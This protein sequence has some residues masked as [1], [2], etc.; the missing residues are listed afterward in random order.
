M[1]ETSPSAQQQPGSGYPASSS[2]YA[3][4]PIQQQQQQQGGGGAAANDMNSAAARL[5][6]LQLASSGSSSAMALGSNSSGGHQGYASGYS[7]AAAAPAPAASAAAAAVSVAY[8]QAYSQAG[9][10][11]MT[12]IDHLTVAPAAA[13][14]PPPQM[15]SQSVSPVAAFS[16]QDNS[17]GA[18][19]SQQQPPP[20]SASGGSFA[21]GYGPQQPNAYGFNAVSPTQQ[22]QQQQQQQHLAPPQMQQ[23][24]Q[25]PTMRQSMDGAGQQQPQFQQQQPQFQQQQQ[26]QQP[27]LVLPPMVGPML[28]FVNVE[29][30][31]ALWHGSVLVLTNEALLPQGSR[32]APPAPPP[33]S[34]SAMHA[35]PTPVASAA[36]AP[37]AH[38]PIIEVWDDGVH[39]PGAG[40]PKTFQAKA[41]YTE[42][43]YK[44]TF[45]RA[46]VT[47]P[48]PQENEVEVLYQ[49]YW[50]ADESAVQSYTARQTHSFRLAAQASQWRMCVTSNN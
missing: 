22:Q 46:D 48:L 2:A 45:W 4:I 18:S 41:I 12:G 25:A 3:A 43:T 27:Q 19:R 28:Q 39:G 24:Q 36:Q 15:H 38:I 29:L 5:A 50:G 44:Y 35:G 10:G 7:G 30:E 16:P 37:N 20:A 47:L 42:P 13:S 6:N 32:A 14:S 40:K 26:Q 33:S 17:A 8:S 23:Q 49:V 21:P 34:G 1:N 9:V 11:G 31:R